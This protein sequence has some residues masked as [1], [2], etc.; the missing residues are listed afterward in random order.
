MLT[1][2]SWR[3]FIARMSTI[4][5]TGYAVRRFT[6]LLTHPHSHTHHVIY[7]LNLWSFF[8]HRPIVS[9]ETNDLSQCNQIVWK[10]MHSIIIMNA[11]YSWV[12]T[13]YRIWK[14]NNHCM[15]LHFVYEIRRSHRLFNT[16]QWFSNW[17]EKIPQNGFLYPLP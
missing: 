2:F 13:T 3:Q 4:T 17:K 12:R 16:E 7:R 5:I 11:T 14:Q 1:L 9:I 8:V 15:H 10:V 6:D